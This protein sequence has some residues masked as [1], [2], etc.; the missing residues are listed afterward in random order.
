CAMRNPYRL[1]RVN[2]IPPRRLACPEA[3]K[4]RNDT[5]T[6]CHSEWSLR[7]EESLPPG[8]GEGDFWS[9]TARNDKFETIIGKDDLTQNEPCLFF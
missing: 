7:N 9:K 8:Q 5:A 3:S 2:G 4:G 1:D 6:L